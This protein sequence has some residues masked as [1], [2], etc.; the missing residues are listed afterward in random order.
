MEEQKSA[1]K[2]LDEEAR[3]EGL[4]YLSNGEKT[5]GLFQE[6]GRRIKEFFG[7]KSR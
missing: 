5:L 6:L 2:P 7:S 1:S 3:K 4:T